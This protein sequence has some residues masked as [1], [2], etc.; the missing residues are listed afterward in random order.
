MFRSS[1]KNLPQFIKKVLYECDISKLNLN[2]NKTQTNILMSVEKNCDKSM[3]AISLMTGLDKSSF[4][5]SV[6][7]LVKNGFLEKKSPENDR[8]KIKLSLTNKGKKAA[9]LIRNNLDAYSD[10][11][12]AGF[13]EKEKTEFF[14]SLK[15]LSKYIDRMLE[16]N[17]K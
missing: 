7:S 11:L 6:D 15:I 3:S 10:S 17:R 1:I 9:K 16:E 8:R 13:S 12:L 14:Q 4:T 2:I 5:R